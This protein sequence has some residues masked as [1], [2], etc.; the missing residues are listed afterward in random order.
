M[1]DKN[2]FVYFIYDLTKKLTVQTVRLSRW[3]SFVTLDQAEEIVE[4]YV[5]WRLILMNNAS[6]TD[7]AAV[8][9]YGADNGLRRYIARLRSGVLIIN[10]VSTPRDLRLL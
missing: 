1:K 2:D 3:L 6:K 5:S 4:H 10:R 9:Y 8:D 7:K